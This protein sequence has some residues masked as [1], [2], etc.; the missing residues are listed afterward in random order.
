M[1]GNGIK[2]LIGRGGIFLLV[3]CLILWEA[4]PLRGAFTQPM[5]VIATLLALLA[6]LLA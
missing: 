3:F 5:L 6:A 1:N 2:A 4:Y